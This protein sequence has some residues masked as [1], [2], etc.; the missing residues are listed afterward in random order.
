L[1]IIRF[2]V[3]AILVKLMLNIFH[4]GPQKTIIF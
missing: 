2:I 1:P 3:H 4:L